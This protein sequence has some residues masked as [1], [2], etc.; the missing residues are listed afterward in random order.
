M[1]LSNNQ[2]HSAPEHQRD[3]PGWWIPA[4]FIAFTTILVASTLPHLSTS[5]PMNWAAGTSSFYLIDDEGNPVSNRTWPGKFLLIYF[6]YTHCPDICPTTLSTIAGALNK[7]G[8]EADKVQPLFITIDPERDTSA[9]LKQYTALFSSRILGLSGTPAELNEAAE[10]Y[11]VRFARQQI[12]PDSS[13]YEMEHTAFV[14]LVYPSGA[15]AMTMPQGQSAQSM[16]ADIADRI[17]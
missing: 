4:V 1:R 10:K 13:D 6:G 12:G 14:Y 2:W 15:M 11:G 17:P 5:S 8:P 3:L 16:A 9:V 7:L